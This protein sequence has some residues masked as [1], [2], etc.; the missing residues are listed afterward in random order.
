MPPNAT[1]PTTCANASSGGICS[2]ICNSGFT[3]NPTT[4][5]LGSGAWSAVTGNCTRRA[6][7]SQV[8]TCFRLLQLFGIPTANALNISGSLFG[9]PLSAT[10]QVSNGAIV[11]SPTSIQVSMQQVRLREAVGAIWPD[12][13]TVIT[14]AL[15]SLTFARLL[16]RPFGTS[17]VLSGEQGPVTF[18]AALDTNGLAF[19]A[20]GLPAGLNF[21]RVGGKCR[22]H[23]DER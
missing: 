1:W 6:T 4:T 15:A 20:V 17:L 13:P 11:C 21:G 22:H 5:C 8:T 16:S 2:A 23:R 3:G 9:L 18:K 19:V 14:D 12:P 7:T 10:A